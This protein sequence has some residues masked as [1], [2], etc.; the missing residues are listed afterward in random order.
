MSLT[1]L[2]SI[3]SNDGFNGAASLSRRNADKANVRPV[4]HSTRFNGAA[5]L[6][7][8]NV[9]VSQTRLGRKGALQRGRLVV[10]AEWPALATS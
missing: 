4:P 2:G 10:E 3:T 1:E 6:S 8:R 7:R 9:D 5:S